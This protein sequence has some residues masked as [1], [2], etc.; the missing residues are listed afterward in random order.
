M[1]EE[2]FAADAAHA[3]AAAAA[4][5]LQRQLD[6]ATQT[7]TQAQA[8]MRRERDTTYELSRHLA[9]AEGAVVAALVRGAL[10]AAVAAEKVGSVSLLTSSSAHEAC[11]RGWTLELII[12]IQFIGALT[13][14]AFC[15]C[16]SCTAGAG[17]GGRARPIARWHIGV[18]AR[19]P[20]HIIT[21]P[22]SRPGRS[23]AGAQDGTRARAATAAQRDLAAGGGTGGR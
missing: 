23:D 15:R 8:D 6:D 17:G 7:L 22:E 19:D 14:Y 5:E 3:A 4:A 1:A 2:L 9:G 16:C 12:A 11:L 18:V 13:M 21:K 10:V 20:Q